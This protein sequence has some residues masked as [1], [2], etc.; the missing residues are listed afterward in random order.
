MAVDR[1]RGQRSRTTR[2]NGLR[3]VLKVHVGRR[4]APTETS[5][6]GRVPV[7]SC[8]KWPASRLGSMRLRRG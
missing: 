2:H 7:G 4:M 8:K 5:P 3:Q 6:Q 1:G